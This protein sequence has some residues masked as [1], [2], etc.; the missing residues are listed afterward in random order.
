MTNVAEVQYVAPVAAGQIVGKHVNLP[1]HMS[2]PVDTRS[3]VDQMSNSGV[4][5]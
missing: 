3:F 2:A 4:V 1:F 5:R